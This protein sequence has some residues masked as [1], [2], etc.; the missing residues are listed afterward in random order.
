MASDHLKAQKAD[1]QAE[2]RRETRE[3]NRNQRQQGDRE[4]ESGALGTIYNLADSDIGAYLWF[5]VT[6]FGR[7]GD[8]CI[9]RL[10]DTLERMARLREKAHLVRQG[11]T[12]RIQEL[13]SEISKLP[14]K[15]RGKA[16]RELTARYKKLN[17]D[18]RIERL[19]RAVAENELRIRNLTQQAQGYLNSNNYKALAGV[20]DAASKL[21]RHNAHLFKLIDSTEARLMSTAKQAAKQSPK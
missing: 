2:G 6:R 12:A 5:A 18:Q 16:S 21:Q 20:L 17:L 3:R 7:V 10:V 8:C 11:H 15:A 9:R 13:E 14:A 1:D 4:A 19:D